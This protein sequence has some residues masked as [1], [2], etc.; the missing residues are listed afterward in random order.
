MHHVYLMTHQ[1]YK[2]ELACTLHI[3]RDLKIAIKYVHDQ[4][5]AN[6]YVFELD[7]GCKA[8]FPVQSRSMLRRVA[9]Y[10][11]LSR[12]IRSCRSYRARLANWF[13]NSRVG[14]PPVLR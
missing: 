10:C 5:S 6:A 7:N 13:W 11:S 2:D 14:V 8:T 12:D 3:E 1:T 9:K 4:I